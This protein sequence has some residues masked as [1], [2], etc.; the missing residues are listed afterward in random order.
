MKTSPGFARSTCCG[1]HRQMA[2]TSWWKC[3][4]ALGS[5]VV[6]EVNASRQ[7]S[8]AAVSTA[9]N[10]SAWRAIA[11]SRPSAV[12][13]L[14]SFTCVS[15]GQCG[16]ASCSSSAN[17][18]SHNACVT[19]AFATTCFNSFARSSGIVATATA[20]VFMTPNQHAASI[21]LLGARSSTRWP[22]CTP[23]SLTST[24]ATASALRC[25]SA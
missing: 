16:C 18:R 15:V 5:P 21:A 2:I 1:Q 17:A 4:V 13:S 3:I 19:C 9:V 23:I 14:N 10:G 25:R 11:A 24:C 22:G 12:G 8:S 7:V 6:P 20:P